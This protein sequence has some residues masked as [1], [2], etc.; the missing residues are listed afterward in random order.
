VRDA[1]GKRLP[2]AR[3]MLVSNGRPMSRTSGSDGTFRFRGVQAGSAHLRA[4]DPRTHDY[5]KEAEVTVPDSGRIEKVELTLESVRPLKGVVRSNGDVV[6]GALVHGY[7]FLGGSAQ[8]KQA[9]TDLQGGFSLDVPSSAPEIIIIVAAPGRTLESFSVP[10]NQD[11]V[12]LDLASRGGTLRLRWTPG[13]LPLQ[14][15]FNDHLLVSTDVFLWA[16]GQG[17]KIDDGAGEI[18]NVAPGKYRFCSPKHCA[19]GL[20]AIGGQLDLDATH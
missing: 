13:A 12:T 8:Q 4:S 1:D 14:F 20:L 9:T 16:R 2:A 15:T 11:P 17:A 7:A 5:S 10:T 18:P 19:E 6:V 3:V